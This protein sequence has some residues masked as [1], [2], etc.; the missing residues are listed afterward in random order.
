MRKNV[1]QPGKKERRK[2]QR[3][4]I[5]TNEAVVISPGSIISFCLLDISRAGLAFCYNGSDAEEWKGKEC[6]LDFLGYSLSMEN[7][8]VRIIDD[9]PFDPDNLPAFAREEDIAP[10]LRRCGV[11]FLELSKD[12][13]TALERYLERLSARIHPEKQPSVFLKE[14]INGRQ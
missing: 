6:L 2:N 9:L 8:P 5:L 10:S 3:Y 12:Q 7:V 14:A 4:P 1:D 11:Q 13:E